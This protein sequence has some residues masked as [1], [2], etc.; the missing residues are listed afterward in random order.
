MSHVAGGHGAALAAELAAIDFSGVLLAVGPD[1]I[2]AEVAMG[3][4]D[5]A[6]GRPNA[7]STR[8]AVASVGKLFT[9]VAVVR[10]VER[11]LV[12]LDA[13][14]V[15][16]LPED[17][18]PSGLAADVTLEHLKPKDLEGRDLEGKGPEGKGPAGA[19]LRFVP[20]GFRVL[21]AG[22]ARE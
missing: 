4:A 17:R 22:H 1:G 6:N 10:L 8:F 2:L 15:D 9:A 3:D 7:M 5:R 16:L 13:R 14:A 18:R 11:G 21:R 12:T 19:D 20:D